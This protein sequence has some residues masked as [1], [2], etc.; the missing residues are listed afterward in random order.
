MA[1]IF[2]HS[3]LA[4]FLA[5]I[6]TSILKFFPKFFLASLLALYL[7]FYLT[8]FLAY[9]AYVSGISSEFL[10]GSSVRRGT[11]LDPELA[12]ARWR[13]GAERSDPAPD[14][15]GGRRRKEG[16]RANIKFNNPH[17]T[18]ENGPNMTQTE[19]EETAVTE[20]ATRESVCRVT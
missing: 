18:G 6:L 13:S 5:S 16:V 1:Y 7:A 15:G 8:F 17:L 4:F 10:R 19:Q 14:E 11:Q 3:I 9:D 12:V 2:W 20:A